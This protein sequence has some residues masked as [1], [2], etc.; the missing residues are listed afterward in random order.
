MQ[1]YWAARAAIDAA[2]IGVGFI[3]I[4]AVVDALIRHAHV[5][6]AVASVGGAVGV[7]VTSAT[8]PA[9]RAICAAAIG[10]GFAAVLVVIFA[11]ICDAL[12]RFEIAGT[13]DANQ[14]GMTFLAQLTRSACSD[15]AAAAGVAP[16]ASRASAVHATFAANLD[17]SALP[18]VSRR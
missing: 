15:L 7:V 3:P 6:D 4:R 5:L 13:R 9:L 2:A 1:A 12:V 14:V 10:V 11:R 8:E 16:T 17:S 18:A